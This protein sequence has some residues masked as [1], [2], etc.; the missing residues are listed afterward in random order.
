LSYQWYFNGTPLA[1][2]TGPELSLG[3]VTSGAAGPY[4]VVVS[5][6]YG[7]VTNGEAILTVL[8]PA[9]IVRS[10]QALL[11][12]NGQTAR[13]S[14]V[15]GGTEPVGYF[16]YYEWTNLLSAGTNAE[17]VLGN[18]QPAQ[19]GT[20]RVVVSNAW[21][22]VSS[23]GSLQVVVPP[24]LAPG[25]QNLVVTNGGAAR[26]SVAAGG[27]EPLSYQ[28]YFNGALLAGRTGPELELAPVTPESA[29]RY[30]VVVSSPYGSASAEAALTVL[31]PAY[32]IT[33]PQDCVANTG[34]SARFSVAA[35]GTE[36]LSYR[37]YFN[38]TN[39][40]DA[41]GPELTIAVATPF[42]EGRYRVVV[43]NA[44]GLAVS[45]EAT[46]TVVGS[47]FITKPPRSLLVNDGESA[48][49]AVV[50]GGT[51][52]LSY[53]W[54]YN[55]TNLLGA[56][57]NAEL[58]FPLVQL[59]QGGIYLVVVSNALG[60]AQAQANL[61][62]LPRPPQIL[63][64]PQDQVANIGGAARF[65]VV[66]QGSGTLTYEWF[67]NQTNRLAASGP[68]LSLDPVT[69]QDA[70]VFLVV[71]SS[72]YGSASAPAVLT[73]L[74]SPYWLE[75]FQGMVVA[76]G[77]DAQLRASVGG[78]GPFNFKWYFNKTNLL[79]GETN[80]VLVLTNIQPAQAGIYTVVARN[81]YGGL[82]A[83]AP[84]TVVPPPE[85]AQQPGNLT[86]AEGAMVQFAATA[87]AAEP[88]Q[89]QWYFNGTNALAGA[90][91]TTLTLTNVTMAQSGTYALAVTSGGATV[92]SQPA[93]LRV[94]APS[95]VV[96][97][98]RSAGTVT[99][100]FTTVS[101][102]RYTVE[103]SDAV[104][105]AQWTL[106]RGATKL[107]GTG[108]TFTVSDDSLTGSPRFYRVRVE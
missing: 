87:T 19:A 48:R 51:E 101:G 100:S 72:P 88:V 49:L 32:I 7:S 55:L 108:E 97:F 40:L 71:V 22:R 29:G 76:W 1:G 94:L 14:V 36:P 17:L 54:Y 35:G 5:S 78:P 59:E 96:N 103:Y 105:A 25:P 50:A 81:P 90:T 57:T 13:W 10:P 58:V 99:L 4:A 84:V 73:V 42:A 43:S 79:R 8:V 18:A 104:P 95:R 107:N 21:G 46:L 61:R 89:Y 12:T 82:V 26:F 6:P 16:W 67:F 60:K 53:F 45:A 44:W 23:Q 11:V 80:A 75:P 68:E 31:V 41:A 106:L 85:I 65:S 37:W 66:A 102:L 93:V 47:P 34:E 98:K 28:W 56:E 63:Q 62:V 33:Q 3:P 15:A 52:P 70:G 77:L 27:T 92:W 83:D 24:Q 39:L 38:E 86:V 2:Q 91:A 9:Y 74:S 69:R 64:A 30:Q 20:Y